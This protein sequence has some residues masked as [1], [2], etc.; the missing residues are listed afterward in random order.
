MWRGITTAATITWRFTTVRN[1]ATPAGSG[2]SAATA[3]L[4]KSLISAVLVPWSVSQTHSAIVCFHSQECS[5]SIKLSFS[6]NSDWSAVVSIVTAQLVVLMRSYRVVMF[7]VFF[8]FLVQA[9]LLRG[10]PPLHPVRLWSQPHRRRLHLSLHVQDKELHHRG[11]PGSRYRTRS[12]LS[13]PRR[14]VQFSSSS[15]CTTTVSWKY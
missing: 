10:Q 9:D 1:R 14:S 15:N 5:C 7:S 3:L 6:P 13:A 8:F 12:H 2:S 11:F 4:R